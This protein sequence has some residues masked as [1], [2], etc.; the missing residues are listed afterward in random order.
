MFTSASKKNEDPFRP[1]GK[2][3]ALDEAVSNLRRES[4]EV[5]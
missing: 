2:S 4:L 3:R 5:D 1:S